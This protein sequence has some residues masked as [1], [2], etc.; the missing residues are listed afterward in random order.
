MTSTNISGD[1]RGDVGGIAKW[2]NDNENHIQLSEDMETRHNYSHSMKQNID[3][4]RLAKSFSNAV[5]T[6]DQKSFWNGSNRPI[7][8]K[9]VKCRNGM[10]MLIPPQLNSN[11]GQTK[12]FQFINQLFLSHRSL[13]AST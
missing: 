3:G 10:V 8:E 9:Q 1:D 5:L 6:G 13:I 11:H 7:L 4:Y 12:S 2:S